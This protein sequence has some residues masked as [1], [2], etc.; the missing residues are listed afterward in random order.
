ML[1]DHVPSVNAQFNNTSTANPAAPSPAAAAGSGDGHTTAAVPLAE[2]PL[3]FA[4]K[5]AAELLAIVSAPCKIRTISRETLEATIADLEAGAAAK[6]PPKPQPPNGKSSGH[7][8]SGRCKHTAH[9]GPAAGSGSGDGYT[10]LTND[11][12]AHLQNVK[13]RGKGY[14]ATCTSH[15]DTH[16]SLDIDLSPDGV[17]LLKCR[18]G[19]TFS[20][21]CASSG[22]DPRDCFPDGHQ[23]R[24]AHTHPRK[25]TPATQG[26]PASPE[27]ARDWPT[28]YANL[29]A[30]DDMLEWWANQLGLPLDTLEQFDCKAMDDFAAWAMRRHLVYPERAANGDMTGLK[31]R[32]EGGKLPDEKLHYIGSVSGLVYAPDWESCQGDILIGEGMTSTAAGTAMQLPMIGRPSLDSSRAAMTELAD[33]VRSQVIDAGRKVVIIADNDHPDFQT[34]DIARARPNA[35]MLADLLNRP[36]SIATHFAAGC[37]DMRDYLRSRC[38]TVGAYPTDAEWEAMAD[39]GRE[40]RERLQVAE[41]VQPRPAE[42]AAGDKEQKQPARPPA[43][44]IPT[45]GQMAAAEVAEAY[46]IST[47]DTFVIDPPRPDK[48]KVFSRPT[49]FCLK[50]IRLKHKDGSTRRIVRATC[51]KMS[52]S[53]C[54]PRRRRL[55]FAHFTSKIDPLAH[56]YTKR[57][58]RSEWA[59]VRKA[60]FR[61]AIAAG[62][63]VLQTEPNGQVTRSVTV[64]YARFDVRGE[65]SGEMVVLSEIMFPGAIE[66]PPC[67]HLDYLQAVIDDLDVSVNK[68]GRCQPI[69]TSR[70]WKF[71][72][73][74]TSRQWE[75]EGFLPIRP[76]KTYYDILENSGTHPQ[77]IEGLGL[78]VDAC[79]EYREPKDEQQ[80]AQLRSDLLTGRV[81]P[82]RPEQFDLSQFGQTG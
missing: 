81:P 79:L 56:L 49:P 6:A 64:G 2:A 22:I 28:V 74:K 15:N 63:F 19:C 9:A 25:A 38:P 12:L 66:V 33:L 24:S 73:K 48:E 5:T 43:T 8:C 7:T 32:V 29:P 16:P 45:I 58:Q 62:K 23:G 77:L 35:Q 53:F 50:V 42:P 4:G 68:N 47:S 70:A 30:D 40:F 11:V 14:R 27:P 78:N 17:I 54:G 26:T 46:G 75:I 36:V 57:C 60:L 82:P 51:G 52:C 71:P 34:L 3:A 37:K 31:Y 1:P 69:S 55:A 72:P 67:E 39:S 59:T 13:P 41:V 80:A 18:V 20:D 10:R 44:P 21:I 65:R 76:T 61:A